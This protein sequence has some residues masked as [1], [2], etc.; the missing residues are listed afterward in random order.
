LP[1]VTELRIGTSAFTAAGWEGSFHPVEM[2]LA[3]YLSYYATRFDKEVV[4]ERL[5]DFYV[6]RHSQENGRG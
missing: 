1:T 6:I 3:D 4:S 2:K 5:E